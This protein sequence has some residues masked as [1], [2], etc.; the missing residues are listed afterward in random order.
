[1]LFTGRTPTLPATGPA[2]IANPAVSRILLI[3]KSLK[4]SAGYA[5]LPIFSTAI[6]FESVESA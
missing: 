4:M 3:L 1:V 2:A 6:F 5:D